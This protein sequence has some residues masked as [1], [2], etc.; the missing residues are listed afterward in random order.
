MK[1]V[2]SVL[3]LESDELIDVSAQYIS[4][5]SLLPKVTM[6]LWVV[7]FPLGELLLPAS[8][9]RRV[10]LPPVVVLCPAS[11]PTAVLFIPVVF[12]Y[13]ALIPTAVLV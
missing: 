5:T 9:P 7:R 4:V 13:R 6:L 2:I 1:S 10:L 12:A 3:S 11:G 8:C